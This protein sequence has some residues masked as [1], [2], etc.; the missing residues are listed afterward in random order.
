MKAFAISVKGF[1]DIGKAEV[2]TIINADATIEDNVLFF[3]TTEDNLAKLTYKTQSL[4]RTVQFLT[5]AEITADLKQTEENLKT[6][7]G[8]IKLPDFAKGK[9]FKVLT[10]RIGEHPYRSQDISTAV[11]KQFKLKA[12]MDNPE[13]IIYVYINITKAYIGVD[14]A[15]MDLSKRDYK[16]Y[17]HPQALNGAVAFST[18]KLADYDNTKTILDPFCGSSSITIEAA[19]FATN[20]SQNL[21][22]K[23]KLQCTRFLDIDLKQFD[24]S[25]EKHEKIFSFDM[26]NHHISTSKKNAKIANVHKS[27]SFSR[28]DVEWL[29]TK[30]DKES[31]DIIASQPPTVGRAL[32][33]K[34]VEKIYKEFFYQTKFILKPKGIIIF[35]ARKVDL[36]EKTATDFT[37]IEKRD[38]WQGEQKFEVIVLKRK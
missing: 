16:I 26:N 31:I 5:T 38:V 11:G 28:M 21:F 4:K 18:L 3:E 14:Y 19:L 10:K 13:I 34:E 8:N 30:L 33:E 24:K 23:D 9:T 2:K 7:L 6:A 36:L 35:I 29:D 1:E 12:N 25:N 32:S 15:G 37:I 22:R 27:L 20:T 17:P